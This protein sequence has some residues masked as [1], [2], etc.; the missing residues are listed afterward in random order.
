MPRFEELVTMTPLSPLRECTIAAPRGD[1]T[2]CLD[3]E[4]ARIEQEMQNAM[5]AHIP[6]PV[7]AA[8]A[9]HVVC[10][11]T[12]DIVARSDYDDALNIAAVAISRLVPVYA[13]ADPLQGKKVLLIDMARERFANGATELRRS[14]GR[15]ITPLSVQRSDMLSALSLIK[16]TGL[17]FF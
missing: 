13:L 7:A 15:K 12:H 10:R 1:A 14:D 16:R 8:S 5:S 17:L 9:I 2:V 6:L 3:L 11:N 4:R